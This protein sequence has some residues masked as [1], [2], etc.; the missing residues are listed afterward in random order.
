MEINKICYGALH[1]WFCRAKLHMKCILR[2]A[3]E[4]RISLQKVM[5][6]MTHAV[7]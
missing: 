3:R 1:S 5:F 4:K 6:H 7:L 2:E